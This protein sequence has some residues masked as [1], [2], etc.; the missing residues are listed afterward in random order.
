MI[1]EMSTSLAA[2]VG[3]F[4]MTLLCIALGLIADLLCMM[5]DKLK[6]AEHCHLQTLCEQTLCAGGVSLKKD[7][8]ILTVL[9]FRIANFSARIG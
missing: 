2:D 7:C 4:C 1:Q 9:S 8:L 5:P 6:T 3:H